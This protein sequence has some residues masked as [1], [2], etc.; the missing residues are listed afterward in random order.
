MGLQHFFYTHGEYTMTNLEKLAQFITIEGLGTPS[1]TAVMCIPVNEL[2]FG[3]TVDSITMAIDL[4][5]LDQPSFCMPE[6]VVNWSSDE[7]TET[8]EEA[9]HII[10]NCFYGPDAGEWAPRFRELLVAAGIS[11]RSARDVSCTE[12][13]M[14]DYGR[15][16]YESE[17]VFEEALAAL[18]VEIEALRDN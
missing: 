15:A 16:S 17:C 14:Q 18:T 10:S 9:G 6:L 3:V 12:S 1:L 5:D 7:V 13:G 11:E 2:A 4:E 8:S